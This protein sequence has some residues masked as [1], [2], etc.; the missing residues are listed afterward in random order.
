MQKR[1]NRSKRN[2]KSNRFVREICL[3]HFAYS[4]L[5]TA[6]E[7]AQKTFKE[8]KKQEIDEKSKKVMD[9]DEIVLGYLMREMGMKMAVYLKYADTAHN[10]FL[11]IAKGITADKISNLEMFAAVMIK[12]WELPGKKHIHFSKIF[13]DYVYEIDMIAFD[14]VEDERK[15]M[16]K[17]SKVAE[18]IVR[19]FMAGDYLEFR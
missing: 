18:I 15:N 6:Y 5:I 7:H 3:L 9:H 11:K 8:L 19:Q 13:K 12:Y 4:Q 2:A 14:E 1:K 16:A 17:T 10:V